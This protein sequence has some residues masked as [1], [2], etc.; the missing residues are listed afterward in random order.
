M[1]RKPNSCPAYHPEYERQC[2]RPNDG[3]TDHYFT[4]SVEWTCCSLCRGEMAPVYDRPGHY[5]GRDEIKHAVW[6]ST[7]P[8]THE[9]AVA[10]T[11][12]RCPAGQAARGET[13]VH[14]ECAHHGAL[15][16]LPGETGGELVEEAERWLADELRH[17]LVVLS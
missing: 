10:L 3:H 5:A 4:T 13:Y 12:C 15:L 2:E 17:S 9:R 7:L 1:N 14:M 11:Q 16:S 6:C 8:M